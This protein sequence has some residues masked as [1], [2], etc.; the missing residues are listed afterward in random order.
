MFIIFGSPRSGTT[1]L[2]E[3][4]N[5][6]DKIFIPHETD[7][8]VPIAFVLDRVSD[9]R[10]GR[11]IISNLI[12]A[13]RDFGPSVGQ[14]LSPSEV[15]DLVHVADY[16]LPMILNALYGAIGN[17][18]GR[19]VVG[20]KSP[21]DLGFIGIL[22]KVGLFTSDIRIIHIVRDVRD[23]IMSLKNTEWA[24]KDIETYFPRIWE[25]SN[26]NLTTF[27][28]DSQYPYFRIRYEDMVSN[29]GNMLPLL[30]N[31]LGVQYSEKILN[32]ANFGNDLKHLDHHRNLDKG[33]MVDRCYAW[34]SM[35]PT[36]WVE[37]C[38]NMAKE[39]LRVF[40]YDS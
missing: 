16:S 28:E 4:L 9:P 8:I 40:N 31:Y 34:K 2:R 21:N 37:N 39:G 6:H 7:F 32:T 24:P 33:F 26:L 10:V 23:V 20:D 13:T 35:M 36:E 1:L 22:K 5:Q 19:E 11:E 12:P 30:C 27:L 25:G 3:S 38:S 29:P 17:K 18:L 14:F 15:R